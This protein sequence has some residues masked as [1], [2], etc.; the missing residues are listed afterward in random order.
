M[1]SIH[2]LSALDVVKTHY[3]DKEPR[4]ARKVG[5]INIV[6]NNQTTE[7]QLLQARKLIA[8]SENM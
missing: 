2:D 1:P 6:M 3:Y 5:H 8:L 4:K 7:Y